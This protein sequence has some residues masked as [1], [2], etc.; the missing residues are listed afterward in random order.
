[1]SA[2]PLLMAIALAVIGVPSVAADLNAPSTG[3]LV[4]KP[5]PEFRVGVRVPPPA[6][7]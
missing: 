3:T 4:G 2:V 7:F 6:S 1:M 5:A